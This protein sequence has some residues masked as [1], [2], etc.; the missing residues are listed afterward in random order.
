MTHAVS[1]PAMRS[2]AGLPTRYRLAVLSRLLAAVFGGYA[3]AVTADIALGQ[4]L[5]AGGMHRVH[6]VT[7]G[8]LL[9]FVVH[10]CAA[11]WV[12]ATR[13][14]WRAWLGTLVPAAGLALLAGWMMPGGTS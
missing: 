1:T 4:L 6:A 11:L 13:S 3:L 10:A 2:R 9:A 14:A 5:A 12:F 7:A 8:A